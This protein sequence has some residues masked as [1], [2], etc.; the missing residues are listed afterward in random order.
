[1]YI[2][3]KVKIKNNIKPNVKI[4]KIFFWGRGHPV[5]PRPKTD[6]PK[7]RILKP[8]TGEGMRNLT[9]LRGTYAYIIMY[10]YV[11]TTC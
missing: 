6:N 7:T 8:I 2:K 9:V 1:M 11:Y 5:T 4:F 10:I 3:I